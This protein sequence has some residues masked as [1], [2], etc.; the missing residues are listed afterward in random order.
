MER[1]LLRSLHNKRYN[2]KTRSERI[3]KLFKKICIVFSLMCGSL[4]VYAGNPSCT[5]IVSGVG[6]SATGSVYASVKGGTATKFT[7]VVFCSLHEA[8][9]GYSGEACKGVLS[10]LLSAS[11]MKKSAT[12]WFRE[13]SFDKCTNSWMA[14]DSIGLYHLRIND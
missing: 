6:M 2:S 9:G 5:G 10:L 1:T 13:A 3:V 12:L 11:A 8:E 14:L 7:D 4:S